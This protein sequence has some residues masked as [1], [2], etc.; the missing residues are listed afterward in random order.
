MIVIFYIYGFR[1]FHK[2]YSE[3]NG[4]HPPYL[5]DVMQRKQAELIDPSARG[6]MHTMLGNLLAVLDTRG[7]DMYDRDR[8]T[9][10]HFF[11]DSDQRSSQPI[12][13]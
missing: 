1:Q 8:A 9:Q 6:Q 4:A 12:L 5:K 10:D 11:K 3:Y 7:T 13:I 2:F